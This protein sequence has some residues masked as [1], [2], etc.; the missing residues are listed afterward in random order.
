MA[1]GAQSPGECTGR[2]AP[3]HLGDGRT[4]PRAWV[5]GQGS[6]HGHAAAKPGLRVT[7]PQPQTPHAP[8]RAVHVSTRLW[9]PHATTAISTRQVQMA[10]TVS[11][12]AQDPNYA[13]R[14]QPLIFT[15]TLVSFRIC[16]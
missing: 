8:L 2:S 10:P 4:C 7:G 15:L 9:P 12:S 16:R 6:G 3:L 5:Q 1:P 11:S 14:W 13:S